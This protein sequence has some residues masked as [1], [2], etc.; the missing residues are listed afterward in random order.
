MASASQFRPVPP[1]KLDSAEW[2]ADFN[3][4]KAVGSKSSTTRSAKQTEDALFWLFTGPQAYVPIALQVVNAK[5]MRTVQGARLMALST[6]AMSDAG[7]AVFDAKY[8]YEF[9]RPITA[10][11]NADLMKGPDFQRDAGWQPIDATPLHPEYP[12]AHCITAAALAGI[13]DG[14][15]GPDL[16][17]FSS[18]SP[19]APGVTHRWS[20]TA[21]FVEEVSQARI[22]AGFHYRFSTKVGEEMGFA[23]ASHVLKT[24]LSPVTQAV[25]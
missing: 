22:S 12:C 16:P 19:S 9:W 10:I 17:A 7:I 20:S 25:R 4:I 2:R 23:I 11:R 8:H 14:V 15:L 6:V 21:A 3:E 13:F 18:I 5:K 1:P 24:L